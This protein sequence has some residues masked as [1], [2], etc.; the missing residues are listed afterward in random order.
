MDCF[1]N[2]LKNKIGRSIPSI[3]KA[4]GLFAFMLFFTAIASAQSLEVRGKVLDGETKES[5]PGVSIIVKGTS[6]GA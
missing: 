2:N 5:L 3:Q 4:I 6:Q 1:R